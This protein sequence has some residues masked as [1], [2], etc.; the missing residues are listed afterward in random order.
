MDFQKWKLDKLTLW[1]ILYEG[2]LSGT[3]RH[4]IWTKSHWR[5][6]E[7]WVEEVLSCRSCFI[8]AEWCMVLK[9]LFP[10]FLRILLLLYDFSSFCIC[11]FLH[12][13]SLYIYGLYI[14][15]PTPP[16]SHILMINKRLFCQRPNG[17][18][19][20]TNEATFIICR[21][22]SELIWHRLRIQK[23]LILPKHKDKSHG[24]LMLNDLWKCKTR[25]VRLTLGGA[26]L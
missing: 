11:T 7:W 16:F 8:H 12:E 3:L 17:P 5:A 10:M 15:K 19:R 24:V 18:M 13:M 20:K 4:I 25:W 14:L 22:F 26:V 6:L 21:S 2:Y 23:C 9:F 1:Y